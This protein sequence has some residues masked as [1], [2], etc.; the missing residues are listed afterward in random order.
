MV[1]SSLLSG[2]IR[3]VSNFCNACFMFSLEVTSCKGE[4]LGQRA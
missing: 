1:T 2:P 3:A 4:R